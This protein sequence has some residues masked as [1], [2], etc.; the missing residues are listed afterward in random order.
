MK[1]AVI[2]DTGPL[3][4]AVDPDDAN[5]QRAVREIEKLAREKIEVI[6][7]YPTLMEAYTLVLYRLG[8]KTSFAWL[9]EMEH[10]TLLNPAPEDFRQAFLHA[11]GVH[12]QEITLFDATLAALS[13]RL[14]VPVW[15]YD[16]HFDLLR[17]PIWR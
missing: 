15:T 17:V 10:A 2:A 9:N 6:I 12:D 5:H 11:Q 4:A 3:F 8:V 7:A 1:R 16:H 13:K 14:N